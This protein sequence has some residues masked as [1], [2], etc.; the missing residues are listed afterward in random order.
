MA[1]TVSSSTLTVSITE[2]LELN[3]RNVGGTNVHKINGINE[4][5]KRILTAATAGTTVLALGA[6]AGAGT[7]I[8]GDVKYIRITNL[9]NTNQVRLAIINAGTD[10]HVLVN[11]LDSFIIT[12]GVCKSEADGESIV[13]ENISSLKAYGLTAS[14][15]VEIFVAS[16]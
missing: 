9:D 8:R 5:S 14:V 16:V 13:M 12:N 1:S 7:F 3:G 4:V 2:E 11:A 6:A 10:V 15:D